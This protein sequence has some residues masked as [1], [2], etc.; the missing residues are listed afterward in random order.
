MALEDHKLPED[1]QVGHITFRKGTLLSTLAMRANDWWR[2]SGEEVTDERV[3][4]AASGIHRLFI[5]RDVDEPMPSYSDI[6]RAALKAVTPIT[7]P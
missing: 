4:R 6:A 1:V 2:A 3:R 5:E 7:R